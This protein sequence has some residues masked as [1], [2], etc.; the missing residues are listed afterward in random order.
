M[1]W[2]F[3]RKMTIDCLAG[4]VADAIRENITVYQKAIVHHAAENVSEEQIEALDA[5]FWAM[6]LAILEIVLPLVKLRPEIANQLAAMV[7]VGYSPLDKEAYVSKLQY[8]GEII[9]SGP[10]H[11]FT[12]S[13]ARTFVKNSRI[14]FKTE[15]QDVNRGALEWAIAGVATGSFKG[16]GSLIDNLCQKYRIY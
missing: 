10:V 13:L 9:S 4:I 8:Y 7:V 11:E 1:A 2:L 3:R 16:L 14:T 6:E 12:I 15:R 5:E